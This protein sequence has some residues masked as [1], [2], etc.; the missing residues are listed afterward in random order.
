MREPLIT[1]S[2]Q[3]ELHKYIIGIFSKNGSYVNEIY[4]NPD[5]I[6]ILCTL[7][8]TITMANLIAKVKASSSKWL[9]TKGFP[10]FSWQGGYG[11]FSVSVSK[12]HIVE[13]YIRNQEQHHSK[14]SFKTEY[15]SFLDNHNITY[16]DKY[17]WE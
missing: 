10:N 1:K 17:V 3:K 14:K 15:I 13:N 16:D 11:V 5:H 12:V 9:K 7:P 2:I 4:A 8:R 6:H